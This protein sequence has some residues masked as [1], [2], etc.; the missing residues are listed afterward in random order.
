MSSLALKNKIYFHGFE[1]TKLGTGHWNKKGHY[2]A[3]KLIS[4]NICKF[5]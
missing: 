1:N 4:E 3:S 2:Q 5:Y